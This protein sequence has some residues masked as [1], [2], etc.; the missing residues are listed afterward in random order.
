MIK[1]K[2]AIP[3][4]KSAKV[5]TTFR[6]VCG[7]WNIP[8]P[9]VHAGKGSGAYYED[10][11]GNVFLDFASQITSNPLGYN[12]PELT[13]VVRSYQDFPIKYA[14]QDFLVPEHTELLTSLL[15][16]TPLNAGFLI[17]SGAE[18]VENA[19][20][21][22]TRSKP[23]STFGIAFNNAFHGR[24]LGALSATHSKPVQK[25][26]YLKIPMVHLP[27]DESALDRLK[28]LLKTRDSG[29]VGFIIIECVQGEGGYHVAPK[30]LITGLRAMTKTYNIPFICDEVQAGMGRTGEWW[31]HNHFRITPDV[32]SAGKALQVAATVAKKER[33]PK[34]AGAI[35]ST[36][37]GGHRLDLALGI[38]T[39][40]I[41]KK[42]KLLARNK[43]TGAYLQTRLTKISGT[44][45]VRGLGLMLAFDLT[46]PKFR[47]DVIIECVKNGLLLLACGDRGIRVI[48]P[49]IIEKHDIDEGLGVLEHAISTCSRKQFKHTG[50]ICH[51]MD[52]GSH[53]S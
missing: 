20:K 1:R 41:I 18:A 53:T 16:T 39:I 2:T 52:C 29:K 35:S 45:N 47:D 46:T 27:F 10:L 44:Q 5:I 43:R 12:H 15:S 48:P 49:F 38:K 3:G 33:F 40:E 4:P 26:G 36:W 25:K 6:K 30:K 42:Q 23:G 9:F 22:C 19:M 50:K 17:N 21:I 34:E 14:G 13:A 24:T 32:F 31:A 37:G 51:F 7:V 11:D 8:Y 28:E